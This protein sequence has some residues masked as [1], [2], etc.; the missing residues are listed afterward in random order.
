M[1]TINRTIET[2]HDRAM[3]ARLIEGRDLPFT[4]TL[5]DGKH[6]TTAQNKLQRLWMNEIAEQKGDMK[7]EEVRAYCK[8]TIGV[9]ILRAQNEAFRDGYDR[10]VKPLPYE[11][12][13]AIMA[14]PLDMPITR[15]MTTAQ[16]TEYLDGIFKHFAEQGIV[17][18]VPDDHNSPDP[19]PK[20]HSTSGERPTQAAGQEPREPQ[21]TAQPGSRG[22]SYAQS[23]GV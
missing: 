14:E 19:T 2:D 20:P 23:K 16:K 9:P 12:K 18:T 17:L 3:A 11:Q 21:Q 7:P 6:R 13:L 4:L 1:S 8:L 5:T 22:S 10:V 15:L